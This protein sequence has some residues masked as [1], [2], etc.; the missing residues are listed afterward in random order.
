MNKAS[1][2]GIYMIDKEC[3]QQPIK[4]QDFI[5]TFRYKMSFNRENPTYFHADGLVIFVG[6]QGSGKTLS[7][8]EYIKKLLVKY[9]KM[10]LVT[11]VLIKDYEYQNFN[12]FLKNNYPKILYQN[13]EELTPYQQDQLKK[14]Y[15]LLNRIFQFKN[16]DDLIQ[17]DN[18]DEGVV[19]FIDEIQLYFNS[20]ESK[21]INPE[22]MTEISQQRKQRRH[23]VATSQIF[24]RM[25]KPLREQF[26]TVINCRCLFGFLQ[27]NQVLLRDDIQDSIDDMHPVGKI[28]M[29]IWFFH[30]PK[31]YKSYDTYA[32]ILNNKFLSNEERKGNLYE[33]NGVN[34]TGK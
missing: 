27:H 12:D 4:F 22:V 19:Y 32:K 8:V 34:L 11:N 17:Y 5:E 20:L 16:S 24:G 29:N 9:P 18:L 10:K 3:I 21:N 23:I 2:K 15:L 7:A 13:F 28:S 31:M 26:S 33:S 30:S 14:D 6:S 25:A 1:R